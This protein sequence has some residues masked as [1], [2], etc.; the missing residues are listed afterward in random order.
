MSRKAPRDS[1]KARRIGSIW[2][3]RAVT[4]FREHT[5]S[6]IFTAAIGGLATTAL[7]H[8]TSPP[9][10][11]SQ[12]REKLTQMASERLA[13]ELSAGISTIRFDSVST[14]SLDLSPSSSHVVYGTA[15][16]SSGEF[17]RFLM[18]FEPAAQGLMD[19]LVGRQGFFRI[20]YWAIIGDASE[21]EL[22]AAKVE[23]NDVDRD[24]NKD[25]FIHL[26]SSYADGTAKGLIIL[27]KGTDDV[28]HLIGLPSLTA[29]MHSR[30]A[31]K[32][33]LAPG[34]RSPTT[35]KLWFSSHQPKLEDDSSK[36]KEY[37]SWEIDELEWIANTSN[38][39]TSFWMIRNGT[40]IGIFDQPQAAYKHIGVL[41][42]V[43]DDEAIQGPHHLMVSFFKIDG[44]KL[45]PDPLWN[46]S[47]PML[48]IGLEESAEWKLSEFHEVGT[49]VH[50]VDGIQ[51]G[52][53][54]FGRVD[55]D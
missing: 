5:V 31:G 11:S 28:W 16:G 32:S 26:K 2:L 41:S 15:E 54:E 42:N 33:P 1:A 6:F 7:F 36:L 46:W 47:Y 8:Y 50:I 25:I 20:G 21:D 38:G 29:I 22:Q 35:P 55:T 3:G 30:A 40:K 45:A 9:V 13:S 37:A 12:V 24:G 51:F 53:T 19:K 18:V 43:Y 14:E 52:L 23:I 39:V 48:S 4:L 34:M 49:Q 10:R 27:K 17:T 44:E